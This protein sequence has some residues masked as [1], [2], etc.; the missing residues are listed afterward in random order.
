MI[1]DNKARVNIAL[2][3]GKQLL[4]KHEIAY[5]S[6]EHYISKTITKLAN[7]VYII[8]LFVVINHYVATEN[9]IKLLNTSEFLQ[10]YCSVL[11]IGYIVMQLVAAMIGKLFKLLLCDM[12]IGK[13]LSRSKCIAEIEIINIES[14]EDNPENTMVVIKTEHGDTIEIHGDEL[15]KKVMIAHYHEFT[16]RCKLYIHS[17]KA[18]LNQEDT[19]MSLN[20]NSNQDLK[21]LLQKLGFKITID[22]EDFAK[23]NYERATGKNIIV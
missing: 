3:N 16:E 20:V 1:V 5:N 4:S 2:G 9:L 7:I 23:E 8:A 19:R 18:K 6:K 11:V 12:M 14:F 10:D 21:N 17:L 22:S 15:K 13:P